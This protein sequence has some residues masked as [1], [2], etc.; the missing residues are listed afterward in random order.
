MANM[1]YCRFEN[2]TNDLADLLRVFTDAINQK[3]GQLK[4]SESEERA[5]QCLRIQCQEFIDS[6]DEIVLVD[7]V[8]EWED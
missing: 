4:L 3:G 2:T 5:Y 7:E 1:S 8:E 6:A